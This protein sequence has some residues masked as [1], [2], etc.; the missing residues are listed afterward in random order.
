NYMT[1]PFYSTSA[2]SGVAGKYVD[3]KTTVSDMARII[4]G[5]FDDIDPNLLMNI[6]SLSEVKHDQT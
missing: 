3:R 1:Q 4:A 6:G 5:D 2:Q